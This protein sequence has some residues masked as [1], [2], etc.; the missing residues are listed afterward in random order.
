MRGSGLIN[1][2]LHSIFSHA[3]GYSP[4]PHHGTTLSTTNIVDDKARR[5]TMKMQTCVTAFPR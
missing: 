5:Q 2:F 1:T 4:H 3:E